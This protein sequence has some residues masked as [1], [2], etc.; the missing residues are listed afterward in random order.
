MRQPLRRGAKLGARACEYIPLGAAEA[1]TVGKFALESI[2]KLLLLLFRELQQ[3]IVKV[4][5]LL[6]FLLQRRVVTPGVAAALATATTTAAATILS[7][8]KVAE[9]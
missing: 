2:P 1:E 6:V 9:C 5:E 7:L 3:C 8:N 4:F